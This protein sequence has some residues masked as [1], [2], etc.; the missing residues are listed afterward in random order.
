MIEHGSFHRGTPAV[1]FVQD[2]VLELGLTFACQRLPFWVAVTDL[3]LNHH[4]GDIHTHIY[5]CIYISIHICKQ[6][7]F[8][9][10]VT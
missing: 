7:G 3:T 4:N 9:I 6:R 8:G 1:R 10:M 2:V 5:T